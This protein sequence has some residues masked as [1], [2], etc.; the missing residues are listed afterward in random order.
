MFASRSL[1]VQQ[2]RE[3]DRVTSALPVIVLEVPSARALGRLDKSVLPAILSFIVHDVGDVVHC[4]TEP[5]YASLRCAGIAFQRPITD[6]SSLFP[7]KSVVLDGFTDWTG[8][9]HSSSPCTIDC[10]HVASGSI[11]SFLKRFADRLLHDEHE[12]PPSILFIDSLMPILSQPRSLPALI[13]LLGRCRSSKSVRAFISSVDSVADHSSPQ[14]SS[15]IRAVRRFVTTHVAARQVSLGRKHSGVVESSLVEMIIKRLRPSGRVSITHL[16]A[17]YNE[18]HRKLDVIQMKNTSAGSIAPDTAR[19][20]DDL[21]LHRINEM[22]LTFNVGL[23]EPEKDARRNTQ[24]SYVHKDEGVAN[25]ALVLNPKHLAVENDTGEVDGESRASDD[26]EI[27]ES[28]D[29]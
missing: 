17:R 19:Q 4:G 22:G 3:N 21:L 9:T 7:Q 23:T 1:A 11:E 20:V 27:E 15:F 2:G 8:R 26:E 5:T 10:W 12:S 16:L 13:A 28:E 18:Q 6:Y 29:V 25:A 14:E 24:L